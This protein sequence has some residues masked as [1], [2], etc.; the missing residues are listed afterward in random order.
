MSQLD[1][2]AVDSVAG[3]ETIN[4]CTKGKI[5]MLSMVICI[6]NIKF[7]ALIYH[8]LPDMCKI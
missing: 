8:K 4:P 3:E 7:T 2:I 5:S 1:A 6:E